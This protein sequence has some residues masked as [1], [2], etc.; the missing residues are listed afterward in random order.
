MGAQ[1]LN[2]SLL[3]SSKMNVIFVAIRSSFPGRNQN[4]PLPLKTVLGVVAYPFNPSMLEAEAGGA[5]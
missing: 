1:S 5:L 4:K 3:Q 2:L